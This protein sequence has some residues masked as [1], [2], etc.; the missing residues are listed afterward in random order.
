MIRQKIRVLFEYRQIP[1]LLEQSQISDK[2]EF[3]NALVELQIAIYNLDHQ[4]ET[5]WDI[6]LPDLKSYW[7]EIYRQLENMGLSPN[8]QR[9]WTGEIVRYQNRELDLRLG[10]SPL[11]YDMDDLYAFKSCDVRLMRRLIYCLDLFLNEKLKFSEWTEFDLITEVND[12]VEDI[13]EDLSSLNGNRFL[14]SLHELGMEE[15]RNL[16]EQFINKHFDAATQ[17]LTNSNSVFRAFMMDWLS[18]IVSQTLSMLDDR[19]RAID[20][21]HINGATIIRYYEQAKVATT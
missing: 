13:Y 16:Y 14:F 7:V 21:D 6:Q 10:K 19:L 3:L 2:A 17:R 15:T 5:K 18:A 11:R 12:D 4:L 8:Q 9:T 1:W 20:I